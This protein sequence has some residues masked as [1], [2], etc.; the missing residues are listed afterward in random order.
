MRPEKC[1]L[2]WSWMYRSFER[3]ARGLHLA[4]APMQPEVSGLRYTFTQSRLTT[5]PVAPMG[6]AQLRIYAPAY[7]APFLEF[8]LT[9]DVG[10][11]AGRAIPLGMPYPAVC[12]VRTG[13]RGFAFGGAQC[14]PGPFT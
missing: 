6:A 7:A 5:A 4:F 12:R 3:A 8:A 14:A 10:R 1:I 9:Y 2:I 13:F 11:S